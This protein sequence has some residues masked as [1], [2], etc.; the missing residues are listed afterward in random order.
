MVIRI[1]PDRI[2]STRTVLTLGSFEI[3]H[4]G[5]VALFRE[6][7]KLAGEYGQVIV[8]VNSDEFMTKFKRE[9]CI[10]Y[11]QRA[12]MVRSIR[13]VNMVVPND[14]LD[15]PGLIEESKPHILAVGVDWATKDYYS[16]IGVTPEWL[17][18]RDISLVYVAH[19]H[20]TDISTTVLRNRLRTNR[21]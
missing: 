18:E 3:I 4:V 19:E 11:Q 8:G 1:D 2:T 12:E 16:Q 21:Q 17:H 20:T 15:Q 14:G 7:W 10:P 6:C 9:P 5:H 13:Y